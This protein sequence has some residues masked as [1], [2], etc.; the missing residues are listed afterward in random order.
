MKK[1]SK[2]MLSIVLAIMLLA[3][4][5][6]FGAAS[7]PAADSATDGEIAA[8]K[9]QIVEFQ[10]KFDGAS[11]Y[12]GMS[13]A[14][15]AYCTAA[16]MYDAAYY[17]S[18]VYTSAQVIS[19]TNALET[20]IDQDHLKVWTAATAAPYN[21]T[22]GSAINT[23]YT[24][25]IVY[26]SAPELLGGYKEQALITVFGMPKNMVFLYDGS[27]MTYPVVFGW[28]NK[29][30]NGGTNKAICGVNPTNNTNTHTDNEYFGLNQVWTGSYDWISSKTDQNDVMPFDQLNFGAAM[31]RQTNNTDRI[32]GYDAATTDASGD[33]HSL[34]I[35]PGINVF[36]GNFRKTWRQYANVVTYK[37]ENMPW[38]NGLQNIKVG[39]AYKNWDQKGITHYYHAYF[40][41]E[42]TGGSKGAWANNI[43][44]IDYRN[45]NSTVQSSA[46]LL[47]C[48]FD[49]FD[50]HEALTP[51]SDHELDDII[52]K[53]EALQFDPTTG[54]TASNWESTAANYASRIQSG[55]TNLNAVIQA[56]PPADHSSTYNTLR[57]KMYMTDSNYTSKPNARV[58]FYNGN[59]DEQDPT[60]PKY[61]TNATW[62]PFTSAYTAAQNVF[63]AVVSNGYV[64]D[65]S[66][67]STNATNVND[68]YLALRALANFAPIDAA[69]QAIQNAACAQQDSNHRFLKSDLEAL[70][71]KISNSSTY[72]YLAKSRADRVT[73]DLTYDSAIQAEADALTALATSDLNLSS[74]VDISALQDSVDDAK[75]VL[76][77][78]D[79]DAYDGLSVARSFLDN[80][81][82]TLQNVTIPGT[83][84]VGVATPEACT[85][86]QSDV[87]ADI[88]NYLSHV[89]PRT[90]TVTIDGAIQGIYEYG[91]TQTFA[92][93]T[94][95][96]VDWE[97]SY[98]SATSGDKV[99]S[100]LIANK[101]SLTI[102]I[103]GNTTLT[104]KTPKGDDAGKI[105]ITYKSS[106]GKVY[107]IKY[108][109][110]NSTVDPT[111][112]EHPNYAGYVFR[113]YDTESFTAT[114]DTVVRALYEATSAETFDIQF[115]NSNGQGEW[116]NPTNA[117]KVSVPFNTRF[118]FKNDYFVDYDN[119]MFWEDEDSGEYLQGFAYDIGGDFAPNDIKVIEAPTQQAFMDS[120]AEEGQYDVWGDNL[121]AISI[122]EPENYSTWRTTGNGT[123]KHGR[124][125]AVR[126]VDGMKEYDTTQCP[127]T[128]RLI[129]VG[130]ELDHVW[131]A[132]ESCYIVFYTQEQ[133]EDAIKANVFEGISPDADPAKVAAVYA[134][135]NPTRVVD[136]SN[137][138]KNHVDFRGTTTVDATNGA[139]FVETGF[140]FSYK[141]NATAAE[142]TAVQNATLDLQHVDST[143]VFR[144]KV[145]DE[146][147]TRRT[148]NTGYQ[149]ALH[150]ATK[151][152]KWPTGT[153]LDIKYRTYTNYRVN[154][155]LKTVYSDEIT[156]DTV[157]I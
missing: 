128:E 144:V 2:R 61:W 75:G 136:S 22:I 119:L 20:A 127:N 7:I 8:L 145:S 153:T 37:G 26:A 34:N 30:N 51:Y 72:P 5:L 90:Y 112:N 43:L 80:Y 27:T 76:D 71:S 147:L 60:L 52:A 134:Y 48:N 29:G 21:M 97:Y 138:E 56:G 15:N 133:F 148:L 16:K 54:Y 143:S 95:S 67:L 117:Q 154:G 104:T 53:V 73:Y 68:T 140:V 120:A 70:V 38:N 35:D 135:N 122:V 86:N 62:T 123:N 85:K 109:T 57:E 18:T 155:E 84:N 102:T 28:A 66:T 50:T 93:P 47:N 46:S 111:A 3:T 32:P 31:A 13:A 125:M 116:K 82:V 156:P 33:D 4:T 14:Y 44:V 19:A 79:P 129:A 10:K 124:Q 92:S 63:N 157:T 59:T 89:H 99:K 49:D 45:V 65:A 12:T 121:Y 142:K 101:D 150:F 115:V 55:V 108:V 110:P 94:G 96:A 113:G 17:G 149:Y 87:D 130:D 152:S 151:A 64:A 25:G 39:W 131:R 81:S 132:Q 100:S 105:M 11:I 106:L 58:A 24:K 114:E 146:L 41:T 42:S 107:D 139:E 88:A 77:T 36:S 78:Y 118:Q 126:T 91:T 141:K 23:D 40:F 6:P 98:Q 83:C 74:Q 1:I 103:N 9:T 69:I 137:G